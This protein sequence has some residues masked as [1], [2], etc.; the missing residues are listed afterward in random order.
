M[1]GTFYR[2]PQFHSVP[3]P[4]AILPSILFFA[5]V[6]FLAAPLHAAP[7]D[8][9]TNFGLNGKI[10]THI[11]ASFS[12]EIPQNI[13]LQPDGRILV[14]G[15]VNAGQGLLRFNS[16]GTLDSSFGV[17]GKVL[18]RIGY[19]SPAGL[20]LQSD[21][22][23]IISG[24]SS[25]GAGPFSFSA[26]RL[27][28]N[29]NPD[30]AF[31]LDGRVLTSFSGAGDFASDMLVQPDD[32]I[33]VAG[34]S[35]AGASQNFNQSF[36]LVRYNPNGTLDSSFGIGGKLTTDF[37]SGID[38]CSTIAIQN[39]G[40][41]LAAGVAD[42]SWA[43]VRY[44]TNGVLD[45]T[46]HGDGRLVMPPT[47][48][49]P[50]GAI[51][52]Q[53]DGKILLG[54]MVDIRFTIFR[55]NPDGSLDSTFGTGGKTS[56]KV[57]TGWNG[58][59][60]L[61]LQA[62]GK[63][64]AGGN[65][66]DS[67][68]PVFAL[69]RYDQNGALDATFGTNGIVLTNPALAGGEVRDLALQPDGK[70]LATGRVWNPNYGDFSLVR[71]QGD[72]PPSIISQ[73]LSQFVLSGST[74][75]FS[76]EATGTQPLA[77]QWQFNGRSI[78][79]ENRPELQLTNVQIENAGLYSLLVSNYLSSVTSSNAL[80][81]VDRPPVANP[82]ATPRLVVSRNNSNARVILDGSRSSDPDG[83]SLEYTW[84]IPSNN[85]PIAT[86][87]V[88]IV[89]LPLGTN[90]IILKV[91]D[92]LGND[93]DE[94]LVAVLTPA[95]AIR[96]LIDDLD[97]RDLSPSCKHRLRN[98][99]NH[100]DRFLERNQLVSALVHLELFKHTAHLCLLPEQPELA[101]E[102][103]AAAQSIIDA[104]KPASS[105]LEQL[106]LLLQEAEL[107]DTIRQTLSTLL[108]PIL[109]AHNPHAVQVQLDKFLATA[110][111]ALASSDPD[112]LHSI[113]NLVQDALA[114]LGDFNRRPL[115][116]LDRLGPIH[117]S[118]HPGPFYC[119]EASTDMLNWN[120]IGIAKQNP[121]GQFEYNDPD[122]DKSPLRF[123]RLVLP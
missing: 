28:L 32:K 29:G 67:S 14:A 45:P 31:G 91:S 24:S 13:A 30:P 62:N 106:S 54:G 113:E 37:G 50:P 3:L 115:L 92:P 119:V 27:D 2:C 49:A 90:S 42:S 4:R 84:F 99:L 110:Q 94:I 104:L 105:S 121:S 59:T 23:I 85:S 9:D 83:D 64:L 43:L 122:S 40:K 21:G 66:F 1:T 81:R 33:V 57:G 70:I 100:V 34:Y 76:V 41:I 18:L 93:T 10:T 71:Y 44:D 35:E 5:L 47:L 114:D 107:P 82:S 19:D 15:Y 52:I 88:A 16:D 60:S 103:T 8:L 116:V 65:A 102:W 46:F 79:G 77:Y 117:F 22:K 48:A 78:E 96:N 20:A 95:Q 74:V 97:R 89:T 38:R 51:A 75:T 11:G 53:N 109:K 112:L 118:A 36:A 17:E 86:G 80:L 25:V 6:L 101:A 56:T 63:I 87:V 55:L 69:V 72:T 68:T 111:S 7:G 26:M 58:C 39:D 120:I 98:H 73:P 61:A 123:Y 12:D 108:E